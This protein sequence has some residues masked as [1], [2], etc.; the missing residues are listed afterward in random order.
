VASVRGGTVS[1]TSFG[2]AKRRSAVRCGIVLPQRE[3]GTITDDIA[4]RHQADV[5]RERS[6]A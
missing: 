1:P 6:S 2:L 4:S 5:P 3:I